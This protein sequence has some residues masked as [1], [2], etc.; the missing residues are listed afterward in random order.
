MFLTPTFSLAYSC[1]FMLCISTSLDKP[2]I[3]PILQYTSHVLKEGGTLLTL[4]H[5]S[6][7]YPTA[8]VCSFHFPILTLAGKCFKGSSLK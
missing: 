2:S 1:L 8:P 7:S 5:T 6:C 3:D 4:N